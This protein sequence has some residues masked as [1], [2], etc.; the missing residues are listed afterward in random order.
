LEITAEIILQQDGDKH[1]IEIIVQPYSVSNT[2]RD[3]YYY[4]C[5]NVKEDLD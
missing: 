1:I 4:R 2:L 5:G 3:K